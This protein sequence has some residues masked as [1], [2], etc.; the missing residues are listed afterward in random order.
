MGRMGSMSRISYHASHIVYRTL[1]RAPHR[2]TH[3]MKSR[4]VPALGQSLSPIGLGTVKFGRN[5]SVKYPRAFDLPSDRDLLALLDLAREEGINLLDTAPAYG[6]SEGRLGQ[7]LGA[8]RD[9]WILVSKAGEE[10][11]KGRSRFDFSR[12]AITASV[13]RS[14]ARLR[15]DRLDAVLIHSDGNDLDVLDNTGA[16]EALSAA[17][18]AGKVR[19]IGIS[20]KTV[21][22]GL[23]AIELGLDLL[24]VAY[25]PWH[26]EEEPVLDAAAEAGIPVLVKKALGSGWFGRTGPGDD[27]RDATDAPAPANPVEEALRF[28][29]SHPAPVSAVLGT[30]NPGHLAENCASMRS[31]DAP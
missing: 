31:V 21:E 10:F 24:M 11:E 25:N 1:S 20:S 18:D 26:R 28:V 2:G 29:F 27:N 22:G 7:L 6:R 19:A 12:E 23:R 30:I 9:D 4:P 16:V 3:P 14:L 8:R 15:T 17:R 13:D 5:E